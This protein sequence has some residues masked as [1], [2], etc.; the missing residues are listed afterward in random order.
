MVSPI[1]STTAPSKHGVFITYTHA[2]TCSYTAISIAHKLI[3]HNKRI[4]TTIH[5]ARVNMLACATA[6]SFFGSTRSIYAFPWLDVHDVRKIGCVLLKS[7]STSHD[8]GTVFWLSSMA[9]LP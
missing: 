2:C 6:F 9:P 7:S 3:K 5:L 1:V 4:D 8:D